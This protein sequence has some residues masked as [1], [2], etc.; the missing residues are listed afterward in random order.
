MVN[1]TGIGASDASLSTKYISTKES[2]GPVNSELNF[3]FSAS[4][5]T[6][7]NIPIFICLE[8]C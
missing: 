1:P 3:Q 7:I 8:N 2:K 6:E 5:I 4:Y